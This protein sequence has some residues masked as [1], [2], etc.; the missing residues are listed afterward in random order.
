V[1][2]LD[3]FALDDLGEAGT[4]P[5]TVSQYVGLLAVA[6][7]IAAV[8][9]A[10]GISLPIVVTGGV[11]LAVGGRQGNRTWLTR[12]YVLMVTGGL[13][14]GALGGS[15]VATVASVIAATIAWDVVEN[16]IGLAE[17]LGTDASAKRA[18]LVHAVA[19]TL[20][21]GLA[22]GAAILVSFVFANNQP[23]PALVLLLFATVLV[24]ASV[25]QG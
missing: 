8:A 12:G 21:G 7:A 13:L 6:A 17:Q 3:D 4:R 11:L 9:P 10:A 14:H 19:V 16:G 2:A 22:G 25:R 1:S 24:I 20:V 23:L 15:A 5:T 18:V